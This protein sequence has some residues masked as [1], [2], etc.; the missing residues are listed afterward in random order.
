MRCKRSK[1]NTCI[2]Q[3][4][5]SVMARKF[6]EPVRTVKMTSLNKGA[7]PANNITISDS[8]CRWKCRRQCCVKRLLPPSGQTKSLEIR[9]PRFGDDSNVSSKQHRETLQPEKQPQRSW[10]HGQKM[11]SNQSPVMRFGRHEQVPNCRNHTFGDLATWCR[12]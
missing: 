4:P 1:L 3:T 10:A 2:R 12:K 5:K 9:I 7:N 8:W 11:F 6:N